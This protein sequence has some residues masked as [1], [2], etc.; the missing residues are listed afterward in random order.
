[1]QIVFCVLITF[2]FLWPNLNN[3]WVNW[4]DQG[5]VLENH[6]V[7]DLSWNGI[8]EIFSKL[9]VMGLYHP[10]TVISLAI[11][12]Q[13]SGNDA[14]SYHLTNTLFHLVNVALVYLFIH[15]LAAR[16]DMAI[17]CAL[18]FGIHRA[19]QVTEQQHCPILLL[20]QDLV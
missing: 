17:I 12:H 10:I 2:G 13:F 4:D 20:H 16:K 8:Q 15:K 19:V 18:L 14:F 6:L 5:Y 9:Q 7:R 1:M 3:G 11:D